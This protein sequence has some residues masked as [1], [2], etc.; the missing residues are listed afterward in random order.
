MDSA[1]RLAAGTV[2][3]PAQQQFYLENLLILP[4]RPCR[5]GGKWRVCD[6]VNDAT[7][8]AFAAAE[9][10]A[11]AIEAPLSAEARLLESARVQLG[12]C[13][14]CMCDPADVLANG[15]VVLACSSAD[16]DVAFCYVHA[17]CVCR[18][19]RACAFEHACQSARSAGSLGA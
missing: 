7:E 6:A 18:A 12:E 14:V 10:A 4:V 8:R 1:T 9:A 11:R 15:I 17:V 3:V 13:P 2:L 16:A 19:G 5:R